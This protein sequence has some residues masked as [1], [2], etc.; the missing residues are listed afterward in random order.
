MTEAMDR[1]LTEWLREGP[2]QGPV[3]GLARTLAASR[4]TRQ[5]PGWTFLERWLPMQLTLQRPVVPRAVVYLALLALLIAA[6]VAVA[7]LLPGK[8][9]VPLP[10]GPR[11]GAIAYESGGQLYLADPD[12]SNPRAVAFE[13]S[14]AYS[15]TFSPNGTRLAYYGLVNAGLQ[16][17][18]A[19][20]DGTGATQVSRMQIDRGRNLFPPVW[21]PDGR[22]LV[23]YAIDRGVYV[24]AA[25]GSSERKIAKG[26]STAWSPDGQWIAYR[27]D[28]SPDAT[29]VVTRPDASE[30]RE[31]TVGDDQSD[32]FAS[33]RWTADSRRVVFHRG[34]DRAGIWSVDLDGNE[35]RLAPAGGY[36]TVSPDGRLVAFVEEDAGVEVIKLVDLETLET[37][38]IARN[39]GCIALWAPDSTALLTYTNGCFNDLRLIPIDDPTRSVVIDVPE[40][41]TGSMSWQAVQP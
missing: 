29:L 20:P 28:D 1:A 23:Y 2:E 32:A 34:G 13:G 12:G 19:A 36:P 26:W 41:M 25:D 10:L 8:P 14:K 16:I 3:D 24:V 9:V 40:D 7:L 38:E 39:G 15:P 33:I 21:S 11:N 30:T 5:R 6:F 4:R 31:L 35:R 37:R 17:F 18:V 22:S 27:R